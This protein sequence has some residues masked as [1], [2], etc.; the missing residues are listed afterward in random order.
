M[1]KSITVQIFAYFQIA[2]VQPIIYNPVGSNLDTPDHRAFP[3]IQLGSFAP[4]TPRLLQKAVGGESR[5]MKLFFL[6]LLRY[7]VILLYMLLHATKTLI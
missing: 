1:S 7:I 6:S 2:D 5:G 3:S 4:Q